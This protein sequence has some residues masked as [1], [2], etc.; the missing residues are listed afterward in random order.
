MTLQCVTIQCMTTQGHPV[1]QVIAA[2]WYIPRNTSTLTSNGKYP[3]ALDGFL[4]TFTVPDS[5][6]ASGHRTP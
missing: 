4:E 2:E 6:S 3:N 5:A 1:A